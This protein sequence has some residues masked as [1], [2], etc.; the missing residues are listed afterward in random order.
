MFYALG[1]QGIA[2]RTFQKLRV[3]SSMTDASVSPSGEKAG[4]ISGLAGQG[5]VPMFSG[6]QRHMGATRIAA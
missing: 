3:L 2:V 1:S 6:F 5:D 4:E